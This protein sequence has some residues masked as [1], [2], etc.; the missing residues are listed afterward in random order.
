MAMGF[1]KPINS[2]NL[3]NGCLYRVRATKLEIRDKY[4]QP[5]DARISPSIH[6]LGKNVVQVIGRILEKFDIWFGTSDVVLSR[7]NLNFNVTRIT[8]QLV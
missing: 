3:I 6:N 1:H 2:V 8:W 5:T 4:D 7:V